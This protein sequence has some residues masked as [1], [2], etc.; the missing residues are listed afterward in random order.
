MEG[1]T[2][3]S[4]RIAAHLRANIIGYAAILAALTLVPAWASAG[5]A[6][7]GPK[8]AASGSITKQVKKLK[9]RLASVESQ[10]AALQGQSGSPRPPT[11]PAG[12]DLTG[13]YPN[14]VIAGGGV[15]SAEVADGSLTGIDVQNGSIAIADLAPEAY[16]ARASGLVDAPGQLTRSE[17][18]AS[19]S[20]PD[21]GIYCIALEL[22]SGINP[23]TAVLLVA[24]ESGAFA[25]IGEDFTLARWRSSGANCPAGRLEVDTFAYDGDSIDDNDGG[26]DVLGDDLL[27][28]DEGFAF[29]VP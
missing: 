11:G 2:A 10:L 28:G 19:V 15:T 1:R 22:A 6:A 24:P 7:D 27:V 25:T 14:P 12:G 16:G 17:N 26:G 13:S 18:V 5:S 3:I 23:S 9:K 8:A 21:T 4:T 20:H 29:V